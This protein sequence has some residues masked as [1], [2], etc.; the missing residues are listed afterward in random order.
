MFTLTITEKGG[1][2]VTRSYSQV[3]VTIGRVQGNEIILPKGNISKHH[4]HL[5]YEGETLAV[6]DSKSTNGT[7]LNG[8][9]IA[10]REPLV[11]GDKVFI[12]DFV[13]EVLEVGG[14]QAAP[15]DAHT[16]VPMALEASY[17]GAGGP[18]GEA[19]Y[20][21]PEP[22]ARPAGPPAAAARV[23]DELPAARPKS[24]AG[25]GTGRRVA[26]MQDE[27]SLALRKV[28]ERL[29][30]QID[31]KEDSYR[32]LD[33]E[34]ARAQTAQAVRGIVA[35]MRTDGE[36]PDDVRPAALMDVALHEAV[37]LG[38]LERLLEDAS[39]TEILVNSA[40][41]VFI[42]R[43]GKLEVSDVSFSS[44]Q[45]VI[46][47]I[48]RIVAPLGR[49]LD[50]RMPMVDARLP[51]GSRV[52]AIIAPLSLR[53][54]TLTIRK[55]SR[56]PLQID[57]LV[58]GG[59]LNADMAEF[60]EVCVQARRNIVISGGTG[61]GKTTMLNV[62]SS[63]IGTHER[64]I[65]IEDAAELRLDQVHVVQ[66]ESRPP[67]VD[68]AGA[69]GI[70]DLVRNALRMRPDRIIIGE[71]RGGEALD[72]LQAMNTGH[73]GSLTTVHSNSPRDA[74]SRM[75]T[76]VLMSGMELPMKAIREQVAN[77]IDIIV[78]QARFSDGSRRITAISE[79]V[80]ME[81]EVVSM[82]DLFTYEQRG[83]A[84]DGKVQGRFK[85]SGIVPKF[86]EGLRVMGIE[87]NL[88][89]FRNT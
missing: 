37:G 15:D 87:P 62:V 40:R 64:I 7:F 51:D 68:G 89:I 48:Q 56:E 29:A 18:L 26:P 61:V 5:V 76:M 42:E 13:L 73:D 79:I 59:C 17:S 57:D 28:H 77:A 3:D 23:T 11:A 58:A 16:P 38:P 1:A 78:Q 43:K 83:F 22:P 65:T 54:P 66:L 67:D 80:G 2:P 70:R 35:Q 25:T 8:K 41:Q 45:A 82:H 10:D 75:E 6:E 39:I 69:I 31:P 34:Q 36:I 72:M 60:L 53:G 21:D 71:C 12:G 49:R 47:I 32:R 4:A 46:N 74:L 30:E 85:S 63:F 14:G 86:Y 9:R 52:N 27:P 24:G 19:D 81:G 84:R 44:D 50:A 33:E 88:G 55:F 20:V